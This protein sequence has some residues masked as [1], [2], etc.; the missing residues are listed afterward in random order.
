MSEPLCKCD[1]CQWEGA[2]DDLGIALFEIHHLADRLDPGSIVP[3]G[4]C[5]E[6]GSFAYFAAPDYHAQRDELAAALRALLNAQCHPNHPD[7]IT[8]CALARAVLDKVTA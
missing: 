7:R 3:A 5:P 6:C 8:A 1:N 4:E 2:A